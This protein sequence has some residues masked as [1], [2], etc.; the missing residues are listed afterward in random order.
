M[1]FTDTQGN[2]VPDIEHRIALP[3]LIRALL[4]NGTLRPEDVTN[5]TEG[6]IIAQVEPEVLAYVEATEQDD[7]ADA[8]PLPEQGPTAT[9]L[10]AE[11]AESDEE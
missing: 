2:V 8:R 3:G 5:A 9:L 10:A 7:G 1:I 4:D 11:L 6:R